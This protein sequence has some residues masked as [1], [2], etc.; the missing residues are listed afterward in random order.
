MTKAWNA[1]LSFHDKRHATGEVY[2]NRSDGVQSSLSGS[3]RRYWEDDMKKAL[4]IGGFP[5][6]LILNRIRKKEVLAV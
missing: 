2:F 1:H 5:L 6:E 3:D 4:G